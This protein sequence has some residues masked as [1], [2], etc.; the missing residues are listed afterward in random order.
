[1]AG[2]GKS[3]NASADATAIGVTS[4][5]MPTFLMFAWNSANRFQP[6]PGSI[7]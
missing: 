6:W 7:A 5:S 3:G 2:S 4:R 1:M